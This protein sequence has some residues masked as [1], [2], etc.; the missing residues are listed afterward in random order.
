[1]V[2]Q[3]GVDAF[4]VSDENGFFAEYSAMRPRT[5]QFEPIVWTICRR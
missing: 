4:F 3:T 1:M 5:C 2:H